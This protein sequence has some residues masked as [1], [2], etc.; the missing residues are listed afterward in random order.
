M[1]DFSMNP[2]EEV[3]GIGKVQ[4]TEEF[5]GVKV[6]RTN[7]CPK[8]GRFAVVWMYGGKLHTQNAYWDQGGYLMFEETDP[9]MESVAYIGNEST[10][11]FYLQ[12]ENE[13]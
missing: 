7:E 1:T 4:S 2:L 10:I 11:L 12:S 6:H 5:N 8:T 13:K 3:K 9:D